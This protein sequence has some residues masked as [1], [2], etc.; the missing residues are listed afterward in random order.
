LQ[1]L[2]AAT[3]VLQGLRD[4]GVGIALDDFGTGYSSLL[5]LRDLPVT[6]VK[7]DRTFVGGVER[8]EDDAA[9]VNSV[10]RLASTVGLG[11][12]AEGV[13]T[14]GQASFLRSIGCSCAQGYRYARPAPASSVPH[15][16][17]STLFDPYPVVAGR[18][19]DPASPLVTRRIAALISAG[20]SLHTIAAALNRDG[21]L[22]SHGRRWTAAAV[23]RV[24]G[25]T[26]T[27]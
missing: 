10:V 1:G 11:V 13:E 12:V 24:C 23:A 8:R 17:N 22:T 7:I 5:Y 25:P 26:S 16:L 2:E 20:A 6:E 18:R 27:R 15:E 3:D 21:L 4:S 9:I 14:S 19:P